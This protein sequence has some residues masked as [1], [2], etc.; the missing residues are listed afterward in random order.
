MYETFEKLLKLNNISLYKVAKDTG[1]PYGVLSDWKAGRST[2]KH[3]KMQKLADY[4]N[5]SVDYLLGREKELEFTVRFKS[6][7]EAKLCLEILSCIEKMNI[8]GIKEANRY[9]N[10]LTTIAEYKAKDTD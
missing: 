10:Y 1:I 6:D 5:V 7:E 8:D 3:D 4:F 9:L 2:P